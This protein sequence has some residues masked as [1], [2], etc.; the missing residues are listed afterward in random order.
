MNRKKKQEI[1]NTLEY[2]LSSNR[3][4]LGTQIR[5]IRKKRGYSQEALA[6]KMNVSRSTISKIESGKF[7]FSIDYLSKFSLA[8]DFQISISKTSSQNLKS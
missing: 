3:L 6:I 8:L 1:E 4:R 7:N 2:Y 5:E